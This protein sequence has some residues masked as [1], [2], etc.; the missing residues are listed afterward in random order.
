MMPLTR[1]ELLIRKAVFALP[2]A[3]LVGT[4]VVFAFLQI[5]S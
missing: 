2:G 4:L 1:R 5:Y 3:I